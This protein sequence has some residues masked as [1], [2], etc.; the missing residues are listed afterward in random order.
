MNLTH[1]ISE[2]GIAHQPTPAIFILAHEAD[3]LVTTVRTCKD[4]LHF[5]CVDES[6]TLLANNVHARTS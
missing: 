3:R 5:Q 4:I 6:C 2:S 1:L